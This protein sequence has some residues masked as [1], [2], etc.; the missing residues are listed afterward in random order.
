MFVLS[1]RFMWK[2]SSFK[3]QV[4]EKWPHFVLICCRVCIVFLCCNNMASELSN[5]ISLNFGTGA[6]KTRPSEHSGLAHSMVDF[7]QTQS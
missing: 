6:C 4:P 2:I 7:T 5:S 1:S 3:A